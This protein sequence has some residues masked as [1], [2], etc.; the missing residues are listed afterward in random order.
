V[1]AEECAIGGKVYAGTVG[2]A[3]HTTACR[4]TAIYTD[5]RRFGAG[6][7]GRWSCRGW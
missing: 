3:I 4:G 2:T 1:R 5:S 7:A 6:R